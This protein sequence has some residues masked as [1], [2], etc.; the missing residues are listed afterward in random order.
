[1]NF[2]VNKK[3]T[4]TPHSE[5]EVLPMPRP[6]TL[7]EQKFSLFYY[8][9]RC[10]TCENKQGPLKKHGPVYAWLFIIYFSY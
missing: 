7:R 10:V 5:E 6:S 8:V 3:S 4:M 1:M 2:H 9:M